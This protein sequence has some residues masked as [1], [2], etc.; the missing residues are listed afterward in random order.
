MNIMR[1]VEKIWILAA[2]ASFAVVVVNFL[3][4][5]TINHLVYFPFFC[6]IFCIIL[7]F[8]LRSQNN[9]KDKM[10]QQK[11]NNTPQ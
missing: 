8:N 6:G 3:K 7:F 5:G 4:I 9:F 10:K 2:I 1:V 11:N